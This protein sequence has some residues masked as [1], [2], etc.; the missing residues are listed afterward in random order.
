MTKFYGIPGLRLGFLAAAPFLARRVANLQ[1]PWSV[2]VLAQEAGVHCLRDSNWEA[3]TLACI[4]RLRARLAAD[5]AALPGFKPLPSAANYLLVRLDPP[6]PTARELYEAAAARGI[7]IR[8]CG[9]FGLG[10]RYIRVA[11]RTQ[12]ENAKLL[13]ALRADAEPETAQPT[14]SR[15]ALRAPAE[16]QL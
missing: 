14:V 3:V 9:S 12:E 5:L 13:A 2:N 1:I 11:V 15:G 7:L 16:A 8:H 10:E 4:E 6:A